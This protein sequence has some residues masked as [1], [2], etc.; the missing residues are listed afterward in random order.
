MAKG[1]KSKGDHKT[2]SGGHKLAKK[3]RAI[4]KLRQKIARWERYKEE[5]K[6]SVTAEQEEKKRRPN[7]SR[8]R[9]WDTS[10]LKKHLELLESQL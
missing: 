7:K 9:D 4:R 2:S 10:G 8:H 6:P 5:G 1:K 3:N